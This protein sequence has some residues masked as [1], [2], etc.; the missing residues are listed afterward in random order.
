MANILKPQGDKNFPYWPGVPLQESQSI[1][2][3]Q[4]AGE[5]ADININRDRYSMPYAVGDV[6]TLRTAEALQD[7]TGATRFI[8]G[9]PVMGRGA[10][11]GLTEM[12]LTSIT[13][14]QTQGIDKTQ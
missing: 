4:V 13:A 8:E 2:G 7:K 9:R 10:G 5:I 3:Q 11:V 6:S 14:Q 1:P 12:L